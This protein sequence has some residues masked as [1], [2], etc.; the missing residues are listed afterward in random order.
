MIE[1]AEEETKAEETNISKVEEIIAETKILPTNNDDKDNVPDQKTE[2]IL[3]E[4]AV[5]IKPELQ[6]DEKIEDPAEND[7]K[8]SIRENDTRTVKDIDVTENSKEL[9]PGSKSTVTE[10]DT[11]NENSNENSNNTIVEDDTNNE[12]S[13][14]KIASQN[15]VHPAEISKDNNK[16]EENAKDIL[17]NE[18]KETSGEKLHITSQKLAE[19]NSK[20]IHLESDTHISNSKKIN[21][22]SGKRE[23]DHED[24]TQ[25]NETIDI[26]TTEQE[27]DDGSEGNTNHHN[28]EDDDDVQVQVQGICYPEHC[29]IHTKSATLRQNNNSAKRGSLDTSSGS[30]HD[31]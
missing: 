31:I 3:N 11:N 12:D 29:D 15:Y 27:E 23:T 17:S 9:S 13:K 20:E 19:I 25:E 30:T 16:T 2:E 14:E 4:S 24:S 18:Q 7:D 1:E 22:H 8:S 21:G 28:N 26:Q 5:Q 6:G 10:E